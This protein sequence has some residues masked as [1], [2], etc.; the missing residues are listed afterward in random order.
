LKG[1]GVPQSRDKGLPA[2]R[3]ALPQWP[4]LFNPLQ[5][6]DFQWHAIENVW[7]NPDLFEEK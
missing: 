3:G 7:A 5:I 4:R 1:F 6:P 2:K